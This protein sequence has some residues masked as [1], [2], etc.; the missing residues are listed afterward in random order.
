MTTF[1]RVC[2]IEDNPLA[3]F[4]SLYRGLLAEL[5][6]SDLATASFPADPSHSSTTLS[7][8]PPFTI[9]V[10][11]SLRAAVLS[12]SAVTRMLGSISI[13][14]CAQQGPFPAELSCQLMGYLN[15]NTV[16]SQKFFQHKLRLQKR[17]HDVC[18]QMLITTLAVQFHEFFSLFPLL[19]C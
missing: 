8:S 3:S 13:L 5:P 7:Y 17:A 12:T 4:L 1:G 16:E 6:L 18:P 14:W 19:S 15:S 2:E 11:G 9:S 10:A